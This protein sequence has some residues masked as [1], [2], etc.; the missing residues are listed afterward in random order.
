MRWGGQCVDKGDLCRSVSS[1]SQLSWLYLG[2][3]LLPQHLGGFST[4]FRFRRRFRQE[5][6]ILKSALTIFVNECLLIFRFTPRRQMHTEPLCS[7]ALWRMSLS[8]ECM[9][10]EISF[11]GESLYLQYVKRKRKEKESSLRGNFYSMHWEK[12]QSLQAPNSWTCYCCTIPVTFL[13]GG[14]W[15]V[16]SKW[17]HNVIYQPWPY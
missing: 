5:E 14:I 4:S 13:L 3:L 10:E 6:K 1:A 11:Q 2:R 7:R 17:R 9:G 16:Q 8:L 12:R 15:M